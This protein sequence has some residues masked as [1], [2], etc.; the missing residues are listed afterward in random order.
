M[1]SA[2]G[3]R[4]ASRR[5]VWEELRPDISE[6]GEVVSTRSGG[7]A[8]LATPV[9]DMQS[10]VSSLVGVSLGVRKR[11]VTGAQTS[12]P[13]PSQPSCKLVHTML[14]PHLLDSD[15][16]NHLVVLWQHVG[17]Q[18]CFDCAGP[19]GVRPTVS[20]HVLV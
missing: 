3:T 11:N 5:W 15:V 18:Q 16:L 6:N 4:R 20:G 10:D 17:I 1:Y 9:H 12:E 13:A 2:P 19:W 14:R 7:N 8:L